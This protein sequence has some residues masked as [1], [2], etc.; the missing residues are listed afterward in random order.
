MSAIQI[1]EVSDET[2]M[3]L[4]QLAEYEGKSLSEYLRGE[5]DRIASRPTLDEMLE[6]SVDRV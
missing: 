1:R 6:R 5:L 3:R 4:K 2:T